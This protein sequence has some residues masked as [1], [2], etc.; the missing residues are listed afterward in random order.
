MLVIYGPTTTGKTGLAIKLAKK[1][2][3]ELISADSR[4][5]Y[6]KLDIGTGKVAFDSKVKKHDKYWVVDGIKIHGFDLVNPDENFTA[7][8]FLKF[9]KNLINQI[10]RNK[11]LPIIVGGT[12]FYI[13]TLLYG[14]DTEGIPQNQKLRKKLEKLD[15]EK[16]YKNLLKINLPKAIS[17]N[18]SDRQN[19]RR[20]IRAIE[21]AQSKF[22]NPRLALR[23]TKQS[24]RGEGKL[25]A[26]NLIIGLTAPNNYLFTKAD[27]WLHK[28]LKFGL[29]EEVQGLIKSGVKLKWLNDLGLGYRWISRY[30]KNEITLEVA[31]EKLEGDTHSLI[32]RQKTWFKKFS[33]IKLFDI[34]RKN[35]QGELE[36]SVNLWYT[37]NKVNG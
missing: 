35:W 16:L 18:K 22:I 37:K 32:R 25:A 6:K 2:N 5:V 28:R 11:K 20:L 29:V 8:H 36:K 34:T 31:L 26:N 1:F 12:G 33:S 23:G 24:R 17:L 10:E 13:K 19:P 14:F 27:A 9:T 30:L 15:K 7:A 4:Q 21:V 3:G